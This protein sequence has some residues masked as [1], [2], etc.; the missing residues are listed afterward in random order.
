MSKAPCKATAGT[1]SEADKPYENTT[2]NG[3]RADDEE[4]P[5]QAEE[6]AQF[7]DYDFV[8]EPHGAFPLTQRQPKREGDSNA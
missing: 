4:Q 8:V 3:M 6:A 5:S 1:V 7:G 2:T